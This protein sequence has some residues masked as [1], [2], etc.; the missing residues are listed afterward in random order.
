MPVART[1]TLVQL[2]DDLLARLDGRV[3][4]DG[5]SRSELIREAIERYLADDPE[6][7]IDRAIIEGYRRHPPDDLHE[8]WPTRTSVAEESWEDVA[9]RGAAGESPSARR[10]AR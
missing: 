8:D 1:P 7:E 5:R 9:P 6:A 2:T 4:R 10:K 3:A